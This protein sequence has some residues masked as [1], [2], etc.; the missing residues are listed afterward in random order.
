[1]NVIKVCIEQKN[2]AHV[3]AYCMKIEQ[4]GSIADAETIQARID[5]AKALVSLDNGNFH[6]TAEILTS[7]SF[8]SSLIYSD[9]CFIVI[10]P[11][12]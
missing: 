1:M 12:L 6:Q 8:E 2:F 11:D 3:G 9:V 10:Y 4:L 5:V 7:L